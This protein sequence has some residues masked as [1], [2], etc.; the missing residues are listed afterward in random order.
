M[1]FNQH[2]GATVGGTGGA[3]WVAPVAISGGLI[4]AAVLI[5]VAVWLLACGGLDKCRDKEGTGA[6]G[7]VRGDVEFYLMD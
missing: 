1:S 4:V 7:T 2:H 5:G 6:T 3:G